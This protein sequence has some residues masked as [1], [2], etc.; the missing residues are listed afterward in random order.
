MNNP[1][2]IIIHTAAFR[3]S[4]DITEIDRWHGERGFQRRYRE[5]RPH[6]QHIGY[7][8]YILRNGI[9]QRGREAYET[10]AH[11]RDRGMNRQSIGICFEGHGDFEPFTEGQL[12]SLAALY[13]GIRDE[14][15][16]IRAAGTLAV[17]GHRE[18][19]A[20]K[21]CPGTRVDM[22]EIR[23]FLS[24]TIINPQKVEPH[25]TRQ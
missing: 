21:T 11:C 25:G 13:A 12:I 4:A 15:Q 3:A 1:A 8:Y 24:R 20:N 9:I 2:F 14:Y 6:L 17:W 16:I 22:D 23:S 10:G 7:H 18:T 5:V 19:G